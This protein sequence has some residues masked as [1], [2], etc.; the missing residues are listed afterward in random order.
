MKRPVSE[1]LAAIRAKQAV[2]AVRENKLQQKAKVEA[3]KLD[4]RRKIIVG[5][6]VLAHMD[7]HPDFAKTMTGI[8][9]ASVGRPIDRAVVA[10]LLPHSPAPS[11]SRG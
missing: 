11:E 6:A 10:D 2:L 8:L 9:A 4:T 1:Q 7:K 3:R 5:G